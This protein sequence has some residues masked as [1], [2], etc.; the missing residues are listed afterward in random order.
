VASHTVNTRA[1]AHSRVIEDLPPSPA[2]A[3][4]TFEA[5][6]HIYGPIRALSPAEAGVLFRDAPFRWWVA[7]GWSVELGPEPR[8]SHEDL[9]VALP[10]D[11]VPA[12]RL[13]LGEYHLWDTHGGALR[14]LAPGVVVPI[15]HEQLWVRRDATSPWLMDLMLT[16]VA[17]DR[18]YYKRDQR[19]TRPIDEVIRIGAE[20][21]PYQRPEITLLFKARRREAKDEADFSAVAPLLPPGD[22]AWLRDAIALTEPPDHPWLPHLV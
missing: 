12:L 7:G 5:F 17:G 9:E 3:E 6:Q 13:W 18:W 2:L 15:D 10:R 11:A 21:V 20:G 16:P 19:V 14:H 1:V 8:R 22:R 4:L